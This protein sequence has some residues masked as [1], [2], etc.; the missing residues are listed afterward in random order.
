MKQL[1]LSDVILAFRDEPTS[2][3]DRLNA[4][5]IDKK[6]VSSKFS[7]ELLS[8]QVLGASFLRF[9]QENVDALGIEELTEATPLPANYKNPFEK[10]GAKIGDRLIA[11]GLGDEAKA[12]FSK[13][14]LNLEVLGSEFE[15]F[16]KQNQDKFLGEMEKQAVK[17]AQN[18]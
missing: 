15:N 4:L 18:A 9:V 12:L 2:I 11:L 17:G 5:G 7:K 10:S 13:D 8:T 3:A 1:T 14:A 6:N 16:I